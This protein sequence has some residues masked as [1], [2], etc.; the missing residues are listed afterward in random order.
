MAIKKG[1]M[2]LFAQKW[3]L[4]SSQ[5]WGKWQVNFVI[6]YLMNTT[7]YEKARFSGEEQL[8]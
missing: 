5:L 2:H 1:T 8:N 7:V 6:F 3:I 4:N